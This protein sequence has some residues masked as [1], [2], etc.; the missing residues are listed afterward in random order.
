M[1]DPVVGERLQEG[2]IKELTGG[3]R[4]QTEATAVI[5]SGKKGATAVDTTAE[6]DRE[7]PKGPLLGRRLNCL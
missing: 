5:N 2:V 4:N 6:A 3:D 7:H 1:G